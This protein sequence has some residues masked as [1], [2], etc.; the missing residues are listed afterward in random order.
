MK[1]DLII[2]GGLIRTMDDSNPTAEAVVI[3]SG[4]I[5]AVGSNDDMLSLATAD[6]Q[7]IDLDGKLLLPGF[8]DTHLHFQ[9]SSSEMLLC[10]ILHK[11]GNADDIKKA[12]VEHDK[13]NPDA[14]IIWGSNWDAASIDHSTLTRQSL[15][16]V[17]SDRP[18]MTLASDHHNAWLNTAALEY[19]DMMDTD[20][21]HFGD[22]L[23]RDADGVP[24]GLL[25]E[26]AAFAVMAVLE[27]LPP[28][29]IRKSMKWGCAELNKVGITGILDAL[30]QPSMMA[31]YQQADDAGE[32]TLRVASTA[33]VE[34]NGDKSQL[35]KVIGMSKTYNSEMV[36]THSAKF[37][38]DGVF[39]N[40]SAVL[41]E[42]Y[43]DGTV[44][45]M[46][47][48]KDFFEDMVIAFDKAKIQ[49]HVHGL[50]DGA[51]RMAL[52]AFEKARTVNGTWDSYHQIA[53][54]Q[55]VDPADIPRFKELGVVANFQ[56]L[57][58]YMEPG[59]VTT[60]MDQI[61]PER[62]QWI[63]PV[64]AITDTGAP[65]AFSSDWCVSTFAPM[66]IIQ[67]ALTRQDLEVGKDAEILTPQHRV[68]IDTA[69]KGFTIRAA[70]AAWRADTTGSI[71]PGKY[72]D[73][74]ILERDIYEADPYTIADIKTMATFLEGRE[75]YRNEAFDG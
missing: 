33:L 29:T 50:A 58:A 7:K 2:H 71:T 66:P 3:S 32:L 47:F 16:E 28:E 49:V 61:G 19:M 57:W 5:I 11:C 31:A 74:V 20:Y 40:Q 18:I 64:A 46:L 30:V 15:D 42:P 17:C 13:A 55:L 69:V 70:E 60:C 75:V 41:L 43:A 14:D 48:E 6:T 23:V 22:H 25:Y 54:L 8:Q 51:V 68:D 26:A 45:P 4:K 34:P 56:P 73:M 72:A 36:K 59:M 53:H 9:M 44:A 27:K 35:D 67:T 63:Y 37:F 21:D 39:E 1:A 24:T 10:A 62:S 12:L 52:D 65:Y 38:L